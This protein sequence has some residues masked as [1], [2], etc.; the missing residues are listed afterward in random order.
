[1]ST[2]ILV[3][4]SSVG[5]QFVNFFMYDIQCYIPTVAGF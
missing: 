5:K 4:K 3:V 2:L 1:M